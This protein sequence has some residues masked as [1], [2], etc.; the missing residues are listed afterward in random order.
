[1]SLNSVF[2]QILTFIPFTSVAKRQWHH[3]M[4]TE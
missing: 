2:T 1:M 3:H 4:Q